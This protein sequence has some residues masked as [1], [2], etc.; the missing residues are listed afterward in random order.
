[1]LVAEG[2]TTS[3]SSLYLEQGVWGQPEVPLALIKPGAK[4]TPPI[5]VQID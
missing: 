4:Q 5:P 3:Y 1:M 2:K